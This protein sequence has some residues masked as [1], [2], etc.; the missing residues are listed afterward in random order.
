MAP[1][2][3]PLHGYCMMNAMC[4]RVVFFICRC[5]IPCFVTYVLLVV[6]TWQPRPYFIS[7][8]ADLVVRV[9]FILFTIWLSWAWG[10]VI[11]GDTKK[12]LQKLNRD[13]YLRF[14]D[15][16]RLIGIPII[17]ACTFGLGYSSYKIARFFLPFSATWQYLTVIVVI[18]ATGWAFIKFYADWIRWLTIEE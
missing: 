4:R 10:N 15:I 11:A 2:A 13:A 18:I 9:I 12:S 1:D 8:F 7:Q 5:L 6:S 16:Y 14:Q 3:S 17:L